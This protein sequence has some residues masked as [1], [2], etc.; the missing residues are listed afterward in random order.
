[1]HIS[2]VA[3]AAAAAVLLMCWRFCGG[4]DASA[5]TKRGR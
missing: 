3:D 2:A 1:M 5:H 4:A